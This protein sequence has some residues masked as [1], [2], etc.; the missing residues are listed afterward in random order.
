MKRLLTAALTAGTLLLTQS[1]CAKM[2]RYTYEVRA[3]VTDTTVIPDDHMMT[4][5]WQIGDE[6]GHDLNV[7]EEFVRTYERTRPTDVMINVWA[8]GVVSCVILVTDPDGSKHSVSQTK[9]DE[10]RCER[11]A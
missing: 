1:S 9:R 8:L 11:R 6:P 2:G 10:V 3:N 5:Q 4:I 7:R